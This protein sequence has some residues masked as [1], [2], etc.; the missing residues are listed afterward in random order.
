MKFKKKYKSKKLRVVAYWSQ[1]QRTVARIHL[2]VRKSEQQ[3]QQQ[4]NPIEKCDD[5][6]APLCL[7]VAL[8]RSD[9]KKNTFKHS[10]LRKYSPSDRRGAD[11][12]AR[13]ASTN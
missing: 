4:K 11:P 10:G 2:K 13:D 7:S 8:T 9:E 5:R 6:R 12:G 1:K 3:Q